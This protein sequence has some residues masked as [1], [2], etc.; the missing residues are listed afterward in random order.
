MLRRRHPAL[1]AWVQWGV[2]SGYPLI[3]FTHQCLAMFHWLTEI[4]SCKFTGTMMFVT[5]SSMISFKVRGMKCT[6]K[7]AC[8]PK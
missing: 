8:M 7:G 2:K 6:R 3:L 4:R 1:Q 5:Q